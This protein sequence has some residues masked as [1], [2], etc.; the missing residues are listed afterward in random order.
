MFRFLFRGHNRRRRG[1]QSRT[2]R[3]PEPLESRQLLAVGAIDGS[4]ALA[5]ASA[6]AGVTGY[7]PSEI[8]HAYGF[9]QVS[10]AGAPI[11]ANGSG[12]TIAIINAYGDPNIAGDLRTFDQTFGLP[13]ANL[14]QVG[15]NGQAP[16]A[17]SNA[18]W[19]LET[20]LDVEWA[21]AIA[22]AANIILVSANN[23][24]VANLAS[25]VDYA[26]HQKGVAAVSMSWGAAKFSGQ[27]AYDSLFT[28]PA[29]HPGV[30]FIASS[31][32]N[33][34]SAVWPAA[35]PNVLSVGGTS[36]SILHGNYAGETAWSGS[37]SSGSGSS[38][39]G[40][41]GSGSSGSGSSGSG[42][43]GSGG[44]TSDVS[45]SA[46]PKAGFAV[47]NSAPYGGQSGWFQV[48]GTSA[49]APQWSALVAIA[50]QGRA[51]AG[52]ASLASVPAAIHTLPSADFHSTVDAGSGAGAGG[53]G[54]GSG[55]Q[56]AAGRGS[57]IA[58]AIINDL[59]A[60]TSTVPNAPAAAGAFNF[61]NITTTA[62]PDESP[63]ALAA[64]ATRSEIVAFVRAFFAFNEQFQSARPVPI[65][66]PPLINTPTS[67]TMSTPDAKP[68]IVGSSIH[69]DLDPME[70][71]QVAE[72]E[73]EPDEE[74]LPGPDTNELKNSPSA[75]VS[76]KGG[77][78]F[79]TLKEASV[80]RR[81][82]ASTHELHDLCFADES[83][84]AIPELSELPLF[85]L[86]EPGETV[87]SPMLLMAALLT[88]FEGY[89][90]FRSDSADRLARI[91]HGPGRNSR[92]VL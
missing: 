89:R 49:G 59:V 80:A 88:S 20:A 48:G 23:A 78:R 11:A 79:S 44:G 47:Y 91:I 56:P 62:T 25:A 72:G 68:S 22:P 73:D 57:P 65:V 76:L 37:G 28:T 67:A 69:W 29:G 86:G 60:M 83:W 58:N 35:S 24:S 81:A 6:V 27:T 32:D 5:A 31:G 10:F 64:N 13:Q 45:Y 77:G 87:P 50:D 74:T 52:R 34:T 43:S 82:G 39:S 4:A 26:R 21:H 84:S 38:G 18:A 53:A 30:A 3:W 42:S 2:A 16:P 9:D 54:G 8:R 36:L 71:S 40:S 85:G 70:W 19:S 46:N 92:T 41:S 14:A 55:T 51:L 17:S 61:T 90:R 63:G 15:Q 7:T 33:N 66:V 75:G 12:Q 1:A